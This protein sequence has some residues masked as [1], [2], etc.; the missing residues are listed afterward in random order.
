M[1]TGPTAAKG[2]NHHLNCRKL[3]Q[4]TAVFKNKMPWALGSERNSLEYFNSQNRALSNP[5][6]FSFLVFI[7]RYLFY[8]FNCNSLPFRFNSDAQ[9]SF[10]H[11]RF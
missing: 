9:N 11:Q 2:T 10:A 7:L 5:K 6:D 8:L 1:P 3:A 4:N